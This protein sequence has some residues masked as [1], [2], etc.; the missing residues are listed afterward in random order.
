MA[1][2]HSEIRRIACMLCTMACSVIVSAVEPKHAFSPVELAKKSIAPPASQEVLSQ[3]VFLQGIAVPKLDAMLRPNAQGTVAQIH[4]QEGQWVKEGTP[5]LTLDDRV[6]RAALDV[7]KSAAEANASLTQAEL[8][9][10]QAESQMQRTEQAF[11]THASNEFELQVKR[12]QYEQSVATYRQKQEEKRRAEA[13]MALAKAQLD[14][15]TLCAPFDGEVLQ[16]QAKLGNTIDPSQIAVRVGDVESLVVDLHLPVSLFGKIKQ[17]QI[18]NLNASA[19]LHQ[20]LP[21]QVTYVSP[22]VE[23]TSGTFRIRLSISNPE[24]KLPAGFEVWLKP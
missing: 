13:E 5:L 7:S 18:L 19:P 16:I 20:V 12:N 2:F 6:A 8:A 15:L 11:R 23:P 22:V 4:V 24:R 9:M 14:Q 10:K 17:D 1:I 21:A 3:E